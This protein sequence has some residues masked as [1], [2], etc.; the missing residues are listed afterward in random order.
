MGFSHTWVNHSKNFV[1]P[2]TGAP[3]NGIEGCWEAK[4]KSLK[5]MR[6]TITAEQ[7]A[8]I[9]SEYLCRSWF[10]SPGASVEQLFKGLITAITRHKP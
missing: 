9:V 6:G 10:F 2:T 1:D 7:V 4:L 3:T 8:S 5:A